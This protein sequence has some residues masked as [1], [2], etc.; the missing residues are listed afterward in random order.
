MEDP[1]LFYTFQVDAEG[2]M[3]NFFWRDSRSKIDYDY[4]GDVLILDTTFKTDGY[5]MICAPFLGL[6]HHQQVVLFGCAFLLDVS[7]ES[8]TWLLGTFI[9][10]MGRSLPKT[11]FIVEYYGACP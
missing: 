3:T 1:S 8:Y 6:N 5:N 10:A 7:V 9:E 2:H 4:F 11:I